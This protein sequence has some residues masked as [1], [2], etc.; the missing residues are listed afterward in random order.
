MS[1]PKYTNF[2]ILDNIHK[3]SKARFYQLNDK[4]IIVNN[5]EKQKRCKQKN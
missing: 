1:K 4:K 5:D 2:R 3:Q